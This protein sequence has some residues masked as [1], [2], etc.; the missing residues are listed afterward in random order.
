MTTRLLCAHPRI[1]HLVTHTGRH[2]VVTRHGRITAETIADLR[3]AA[4]REGLRLYPEHPKVALALV[5]AVGMM[6]CE[7]Q[8]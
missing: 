3:A 5:R 2:V 6:E 7:A 4:R 8:P 1:T